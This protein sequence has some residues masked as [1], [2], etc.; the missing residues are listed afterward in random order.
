[1]FQEM[2][3]EDLKHAHRVVDT[4]NEEPAN[5]AHQLNKYANEG[6]ICAFV[7]GGLIIMKKAYT[8]VDNYSMQLS[9]GGFTFPGVE[10][11]NA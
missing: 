6:Y 5:V 3:K 2:L 1:M 4:E 7:I 10:L 8:P 11:G 9:P